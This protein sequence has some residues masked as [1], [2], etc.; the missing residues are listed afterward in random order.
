MEQRE[1]RN[2]RAI[3]GRIQ[4]IQQK[5]NRVL[6]EFEEVRIVFHVDPRFKL[7]PDGQEVDEGFL[8]SLIQSIEAVANGREERSAFLRIDRSRLNP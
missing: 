2:T 3:G 6:D 5:R 1:Q 7:H 4:A 8:V